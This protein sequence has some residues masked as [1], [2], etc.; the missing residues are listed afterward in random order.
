MNRF[1]KP[2]ITLLGGACFVILAVGILNWKK[3]VAEKEDE[4]DVV[5]K[6]QSVDVDE[7]RDE[8]DREGLENRVLRKAETVIQGRTSRILVV[9]ERYLF[10]SASICCHLSY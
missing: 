1:Q 7:V 5:K 8:I 4:V 6:K 9:V 3:K 2:A 10:E